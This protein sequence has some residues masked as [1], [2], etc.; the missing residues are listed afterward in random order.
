[1][2]IRTIK[3]MVVVT[4]SQN[5]EIERSA[6]YVFDGKAPDKSIFGILSH[7]DW[8]NEARLDPAILMWGHPFRF[9]DG[10]SPNKS[11]RIEDKERMNELDDYFARNLKVIGQIDTCFSA[12]EA[13]SLT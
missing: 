1:M 3:D 7:I 8:R 10:D 9:S 12:I 6:V 13:R 2:E 11:S 5:R 4:S